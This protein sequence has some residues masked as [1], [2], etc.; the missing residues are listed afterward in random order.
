MV[1]NGRPPGFIVFIFGNFIFFGCKEIK[2]K[3]NGFKW[4][5]R[6]VQKGFGVMKCRKQHK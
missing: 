6:G 5:L 3:G 1:R 4:G 2:D